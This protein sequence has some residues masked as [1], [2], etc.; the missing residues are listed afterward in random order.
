MSLDDF[1]DSV[2]A[3]LFGYG[4]LEKVFREEGL[5]DVAVNGTDVFVQGTGFPGWRKADVPIRSEQQIVSAINRAAGKTTSVALNR[6]HPIIHSVLVPEF[7][8]RLS[9]AV[10]PAAASHP[11]IADI[12]LH[13]T[14]KPITLGDIVTGY[15]DLPKRNANDLLSMGADL[16]ERIAQLAQEE[17]PWLLDGEGNAGSAEPV[18]FGGMSP[19]AARYLLGSMLIGLSVFSAGETGSGK[20]TLLRAL[21]AA[22]ARVFRDLSPR[23]VIVETH[24]VELDLSH[25][26]DYTRNAVNFVTHAAEPRIEAGELVQLALRQ[27]PDRF[28]VGEARGG[29]ICDVLNAILTGHPGFST[30]HT[31]S[32]ETLPDRIRLMLAQNEFS[33]KIA[34]GAAAAKIMAHTI[35]VM[36]FMRRLGPFRLVDSIWESTGETEGKDDD[37]V[38]TFRPMFQLTTKE[39]GGVP[40]FTMDGPLSE[41]RWVERARLFGLPTSWF[42]PA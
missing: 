5:V 40:R 42:R 9:A 24:T 28:G 8:A 1:V 36:V 32:L 4:P 16:K 39:V 7:G 33:I 41:S 31:E 17:W 14:E 15:P 11:V 37:A 12:R 20:T 23:F 26:G 25:F 22:Y 38:P 19:A 27:N 34:Q 35:H 2:E 13:A 18:L 21:L 3:D 10:P 29:E 30:F 6:T